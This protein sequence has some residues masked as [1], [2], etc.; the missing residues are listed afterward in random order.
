MKLAT[1]AYVPGKNFGQPQV[2]MQNIRKFRSTHPVQLFSHEWEDKVDVKIG[3]PEILKFA[4]DKYGRVINWAISGLIFWTACRIAVAQ[5]TDY[6]LFVEPDCRVGC[7]GWDGK[8]FQEFFE[9]REE[10]GRNYIM[11]GSAVIYAPF[12]HSSEFAR[13]FYHWYTHQEMKVP[14]PIYG[15]AGPLPQRT[16]VYPNGALGI[17]DVKWIAE[18]ID[19]RDTAK[20]AT[21]EAWDILLAIKVWEV[22]GPNAFDAVAHLN[23]AYSGCGETLNTEEERMKWL[24]EG[25]FVAV[26]QVKTTA[27]V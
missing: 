1:Y 18:H 25:K 19:L 15:G 16:L 13:R 3:N 11:G 4:T 22:F 26:H 2:F 27:T 14:V 5:E 23:S 10:D 12:S 21:T 24:R 17:Y 6:M 20:L 8:M 7:D 9:K